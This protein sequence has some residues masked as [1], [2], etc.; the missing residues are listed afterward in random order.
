MRLA[1]LFVL[2]A[3]PAGCDEWPLFRHDPQLTGR[4]SL[5]GKITDPAVVGE[6]FVGAW[7]GWLVASPAPGARTS[8]QADLRQTDLQALQRQ[9]GLGAPLHDLRGDG[10]LV[11]VAQG[12]GHRIGKIMPD[13]AGPQRV[14]FDNAFGY[15]GGERGHLYSYE[16]GS[17]ERKEIWTT[18]P[19]PDMFMPL[20]LLLNAD[21]DEEPEVV[22][23]THYRVMVFDARTGRKDAEIR[24]HGYRNYGFFGAEDI[25]HDGKPEY[26]IITDF[27]SHVDVVDYEDGELKLLWRRDI[28]PNLESRAKSVRVGPDPIFD[29]DGDGRFELVFNL[30]N[31]VGDEQWHLVAYDA[32]DGTLKWD[33]PQRFMV[34]SAQLHGE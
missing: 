24:I 27:S 3:G 7:E 17:D 4:S 23:A 32:L 15:Q 9:F 5:V 8:V 34:G 1:F 13:A 33:L 25:D 12:T 19:E 6:Y 16:P 22:V 11:P 2:T 31:D 29:V 10:Q 21:E 20:V 26:A 28:D 30:F 14:E 18:A